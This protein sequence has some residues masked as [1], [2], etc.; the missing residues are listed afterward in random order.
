MKKYVKIYGHVHIIDV[1]TNKRI[2]TMPGLHLN[3]TGKE[4]IT[5]KVMKVIR[6]IFNGNQESIL[7][8]EW[9]KEGKKTGEGSID[10][11]PQTQQQKGPN[12]IG[13]WEKKDE[14]KKIKSEESPQKQLNQQGKLKG[15]RIQ[16]REDEEEKVEKKQNIQQQSLQQEIFDG[17][18][19]QEEHTEEEDDGRG[20]QHDQQE[21]WDV[22]LLLEGKEGE[23][24][25]GTKSRS[26]QYFDQEII[27]RTKKDSR[28]RYG[29]FLWE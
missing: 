12:E 1:E 3:H 14:V 15:R 29:D 2:F 21:G 27:K 5:T 16:E 13:M 18:N 24:I 17:K 8:L 7:K 26:N 22:S 28:L 25:V 19:I 23:I 10:D 11:H 4:Q 20:R 9:K 6:D